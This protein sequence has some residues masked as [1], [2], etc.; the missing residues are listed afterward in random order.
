M[1][2]H[3]QL[4]A[5]LALVLAFTLNARGEEPEAILVVMGDQ[6][7][8]YERTAQFVG[9][10]D[11]LRQKHPTVPL[12]VLLD[13]DTQEYGN[14]LAR[15]THGAIDFQM[16]RELARRAPTYL[17][18][19]NH[20]PEFYDVAETV[21][22]VRATG[23][24]PLSNLRERG[25]GKYFAA[26]S[27][28]LKL[29]AHEFALIGL[30]TDRLATFRVAVRPGLDPADPVVWGRENIAT[31][32]QGRPLILLSHA[33]LEADRELLGLVPDGTLFAG[34]HDHLR[35]VQPQGRTMY[36]HSGSWNSHTS[37]I[38]L[39]R[40][41]AGQLV[42][43]VKQVALTEKCPVNSSIAEFISQ[44]RAEHGAVEDTAVV[45]RLEAALPADEAA[46]FVC[47]SVRKATGVDA[48]FIG[49]TTFGA[50]LPAGA[51]TQQ[52]FDACVR[53]DGG[54]MVS[55]IDGVR[56]REL[57]AHANQGPDTPFAER[58]GDYLVAAGPERV[59]PDRRYRIATTDWGAKNTTRYFGRELIAWRE[60]P[61]FKLKATV[62]AALAPKE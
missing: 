34:A 4:A 51:V 22:R 48:V 61:E 24:V 33:G 52:D 62:R 10:V 19:G 3:R 59:L 1:L 16:F 39:R 43:K 11:Q 37:I 45:G 36:F 56:L 46:R 58:R 44:V 21:E 20:D 27:V 31:L 35:F 53:F 14:A 12:A 42:W 23:V 29:G 60:Q 54:I 15:R 6:H 7:S 5:F 55:E 30:T 41:P 28:T 57:L 49:H 9:L 18:L 50:G 32:A 25:T 2:L 47:E 40:D 26:P 38:W 13:G 8:A 17:N